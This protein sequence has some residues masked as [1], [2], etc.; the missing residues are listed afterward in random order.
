M[1]RLTRIADY[2]VLLM[3]NLAASEKPRLT[4]ADLSNMTHIPAPTVSKILQ[5]LQG[6]ALLSSVRGAHG[7][8]ALLRGAKDISVADI[9]Q[10]FDGKLALTECN[11]AESHC[12]QHEVC[13]ISSNWQSINRSIARVLKTISLADMMA[14]DFEPEFCLVTQQRASQW[15]IVIEESQPCHGCAGSR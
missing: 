12:D 5:T 13:G 3:A 10:C 14:D 15:P 8:Y 6:G 4:A 7:G 9:L 11:L 1:L 2:G